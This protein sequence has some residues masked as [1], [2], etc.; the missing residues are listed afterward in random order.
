MPVAAVEAPIQV[1]HTQVSNYAIRAVVPFP[2]PV[3]FMDHI[4]GLTAFLS[5]KGVV[6]GLGAFGLIST[7]LSDIS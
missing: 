2:I 4:M 6:A 3:N 5:A 1:D 7:T